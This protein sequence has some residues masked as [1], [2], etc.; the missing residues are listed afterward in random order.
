VPSERKVAL[1]RGINVGTSTRI[2]MP[3]LRAVFERL[4]A[5]DVATYVQS[6]NVVFTGSVTPAALELAIEEEFGVAP[7]VVVLTAAELR[8]VADE[9]PLRSMNADPSRLFVTFA[10][11]VPS[12]IEAPTGIEPEVVV[13][14]KHAVYQHSPDGI[15]KTKVP[16]RFTKSLGPTATTRNLRTV[17]ALLAMLDA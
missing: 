5:T 13:I 17:D 7:R 15:G 2:P 9:N 16:A 11:A 8:R 3:A 1:L 6:G 10:D 14:G 12:S 4:G